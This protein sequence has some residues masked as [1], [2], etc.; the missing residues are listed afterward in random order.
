MILLSVV[1]IIAMVLVKK[2]HGDSAAGEG[3][4]GSNRPSSSVAA[5]QNRDEISPTWIANNPAS[6]QIQPVAWNTSASN[7]VITE[8]DRTNS[9][10][11]SRA[12]EAAL[13]RSEIGKLEKLGARTDQSSLQLILSDLTN[14]N[15]SIR[16][17]ACDA[18]I[19]F[20]SA[21]AIP[22]LKE[23]AGIIEDPREK[24]A[25][26]DAAEFLALPSFGDS[27]NPAQVS[28]NAA[29]RVRLRGKNQAPAASSTK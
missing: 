16:A 13:I 21:E 25:F 11:L 23:A 6:A 14:A 8:G 29:P 19:Q 10:R 3:I 20:G 18:A 2:G 5:G 28:S 22:R 24:V 9:V 27:S 1:A 7:G 12:Q 15:K 17:A 4:A 26:L